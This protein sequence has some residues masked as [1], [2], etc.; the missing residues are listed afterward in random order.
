MKVGGCLRIHV[1]QTLI[2][3]G[4]PSFLGLSSQ[5]LSHSGIDSRAREESLG[6]G[7]D[8]KPCASHDPNGFPVPV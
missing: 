4:L 3:E 1:F 8:I 2:E 6:E 7:F 5:S